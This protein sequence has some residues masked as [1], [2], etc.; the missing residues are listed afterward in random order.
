MIVVRKTVDVV[1]RSTVIGSETGLAALFAHQT[2]T[3][4]RIV[5]AQTGRNARTVARLKSSTS[6]AQTFGSSAAK[7]S[8]TGTVT[9]HT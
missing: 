4:A 8:I 2:D 9:P 1:T 7:T 3:I 6:T 5:P